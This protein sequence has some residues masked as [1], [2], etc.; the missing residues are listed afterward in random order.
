MP[1]FDLDDFYCVI[2][3]V[4][5]KKNLCV[6]LEICTRKLLKISDIYICMHASIS[7]NLKL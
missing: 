5:E 1:D 4:K 7:V 2:S 6:Q 3:G